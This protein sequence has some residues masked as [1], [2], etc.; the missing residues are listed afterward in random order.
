M[1]ACVPGH[2]R[3]TLS[4]VR[5]IRE[6]FKGPIIGASSNYCSELR[7][8]GCDLLRG[9]QE[10]CSRDCFASV[11]RDER[12]SRQSSRDCTGCRSARRDRPR[13]NHLSQVPNNASCSEKGPFRD[14]RAG[15]CRRF[16]GAL[17]ITGV[18][19][20]PAPARVSAQVAP[21][22]RRC[23]VQPV[24]YS[25]AP[26]VSKRREAQHEI[27]NLPIWCRLTI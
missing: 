4:L 23:G 22:T 11:D 1:D 7:S 10:Q 3:T 6:H 24:G 14:D 16:P 21:A 5:E 27:F 8:A 18:S 25:V 12:T 9:R 2:R 13:L 26:R 15:A 19:S 20:N 17:P